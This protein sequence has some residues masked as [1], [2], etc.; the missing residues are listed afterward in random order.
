MAAKKTF[1]KELLLFGSDTIFQSSETS[2]IGKVIYWEALYFIAPAISFSGICGISKEVQNVEKSE[3]EKTASLVLILA[4]C[5]I[6]LTALA[7]LSF[8]NN[9]LDFS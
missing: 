9:P 4:S 6:A 5:K 7:A 2:E 8:E 1:T 3:I